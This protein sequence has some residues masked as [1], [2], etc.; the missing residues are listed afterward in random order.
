M[1]KV[2]VIG[3]ALAAFTILS[4]DAYAHGAVSYP[5]SR[6]YQCYKDGGFWGGSEAV[7]NPGCRESVVISGAYPF[8]QWNEVAANPNP[9]SDPAAIRKAVPDGTLCAAGDPKKKG[10]DTPQNKGWRLTQLSAG[11]K[12]DLTWA[13]TAPHNPARLTV[14]ITKKG[15]DYGSRALRW[16]DL[17]LDKPL[18]DGQMPQPN[19]NMSP[20]EYR[21]PI[22]IPEDRNGKAVIYS[23]WQREDAG[24]E[25]FFNCSDVNILGK[26]D[27]E[28]PVN[29]GDEWIE[30]KPFIT[31]ADID[32]LAV[33][34]TVQ[35]RVLGRN[36]VS[37]IEAFTVKV[38]VT[39]KN[40]S[41]QHWAEELANRINEEH[42]TIAMIGVHGNGGIHFDP[43]N[44]FENLVWLKNRD[45]SSAFTIISGEKPGA[46]EKP[47]IEVENSHITVTE[48]SYN[49]GYPMRVTYNSEVSSL[50]W[51]ALTA[52]FR[53]QKAASV[54][55]VKVLTGSPDDGLGEVRAWV[56]ANKVGTAHFR[57]TATGKNGAVTKNIT[58]NVKSTGNNA[59]ADFSPNGKEYHVGDQVTYQGAVYHCIQAHRSQPDWTPDNAHTLWQEDN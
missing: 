7:P 38:L 56:P 36:K 1:K 24:N 39:D 45:H 15:I 58:V 51:E 9:R 13:A 16:S 21:I 37:G 57:V 44:I 35:F 23:I 6:Q 18:Y 22:K 48:K 5:I 3:G 29:P 52:D 49:E 46:E 14:Y 55:P 19:R 40:I 10:L 30:E 26:G 2:A 25:G 54:Q 28:Q 41:G 33:G 20:A 4:N 50:K 59:V 27:A 17:D 47:I 8:Q 32:A 12:I 31:K 11:E 43:G 42:A 53:L 34:D